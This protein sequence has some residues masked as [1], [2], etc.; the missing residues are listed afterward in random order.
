MTLKY[1]YSAIYGFL[2]THPVIGLGIFVV[3]VLFIWSKPR[4][5][6][7]FM[8]AILYLTVVLFIFDYFMEKL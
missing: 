7:R 3:M 5:S 4:Q 2:T 6:F 8:L 1:I